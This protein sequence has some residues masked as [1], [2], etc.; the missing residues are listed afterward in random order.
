MIH[1]PSHRHQEINN[2]IY[3]IITLQEQQQQQQQQLIMA[4]LFRDDISS[5]KS[6]SGSVERKLTSRMTIAFPILTAIPKKKKHLFRSLSLNNDTR[7]NKNKKSV[8]FARHVTIQYVPSLNDYSREELN[9]LYVTKQ[10]LQRIQKENKHTLKLMKKGIWPGEK[11]STSRLCF[12][13]L[14]YE[15]RDL[16]IERTHWIESSV[17]AILDRAKTNGNDSIDNV[18]IDQVY[19]KLTSPA[20][21]SAQKAANWDA[22]HCRKYAY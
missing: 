21:Q 19:T 22:E 7:N 6:Y 13:G 16:R 17:S 4:P 9:E 2:S 3:N 5:T 20:Q 14:E 18:W 8:K 15:L 11:E 12:R 10:D 1:D